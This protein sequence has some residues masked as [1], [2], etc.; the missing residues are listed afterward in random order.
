[1]KVVLQRV[2]QASCTVD[3]EITGAIETGFCAFIGF[4]KG[5]TSACFE[6]M[7][8][9]I[10]TLRVFN[11]K[12][13]KMNKSLLDVGGKVL[14]ISQFTLYAS[15]RGGRRPS[16]SLAAPAL[17]AK[18]LYEEFNQALSKRVEVKT[19]I[20]QAD[21]DIAL[22]NDGPVTILLDEQELFG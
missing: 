14:S 18:K 6:K 5:D 7:V 17:E 3:K 2:S 10:V 20:F 16:F 9:K 13:G 8:D 4:K 19:G 21:M 22:I 12:N 11:D 15:C 1:M